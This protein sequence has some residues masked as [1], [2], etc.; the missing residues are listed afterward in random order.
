MKLGTTL[1]LAA[2]LAW[3]QLI[4]ERSKLIAA[5]LG[6]LFATLLV[7]MQQGFRD[8]LYDTAASAPKKLD[9]DIFILHRQT[10]ALWRTVQFE[11]PELMRT[12]SHPD[13]K[14]VTPVYIGQAPW[15]NPVTRGKRTL[16]VWGADPY[17]GAFNGAEVVPYA[18]L[19]VQS[20]NILFDRASRPEFGPVAEL[21]E[22]GNVYSEINDRRVH[23]VGLVRIGTSFAADGNVITS[24][25]NFFR[26]FPMRSPSMVDIG[27][28][29]LKEGADL[30]RVKRDLE[31]LMDE[32]VYVFTYD[33]LRQFELT[34]WQ[35]GAPIGF[36]F[37]MGMVM[38]LVVGMVIVYQILF[39]DIMNHL[40]EYATLKAMGY[41]HLYLVCVVFA[42]AM[43]LAL[44]GFFPGMIASLGLYDLAESFTYI[45]MPMPLDKIINVFVMIFVMCFVSG[46]FAIKRLRKANPADMF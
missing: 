2:R 22:K 10:E 1:R 11:R 29:R 7:F 36:I 6:V 42:E 21:L 46:L 38:G 41:P 27:A 19:L 44:L 18:P 5:V 39:T 9:G 16:M 34:Y 35:N 32:N 23:V 30:N 3:R 13:V 25:Q 24:D 40:S 33:E 4:H 20:D 28:V 43:I 31:A 45:P 14:D 26:M 37:G 15:K 17:S 8:S 12:L